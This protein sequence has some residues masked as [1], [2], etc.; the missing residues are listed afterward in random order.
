MVRLDAFVLILIKCGALFSP[1]WMMIPRAQNHL[2]LSLNSI[3]VEASNFS[4]FI[5]RDLQIIAAFP[6]NIVTKAFN[7]P[8]NSMLGYP[9]TNIISVQDR[10]RLYHAIETVKLRSSSFFVDFASL[11]NKPMHG[12]F[13]RSDPFHFFIANPLPIEFLPL[14]SMA[15]DCFDKV[16][17]MATDD[18]VKAGQVLQNLSNTSQGNRCSSCGT[19]ISG[20]TMYF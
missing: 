6:Q 8:L 14:L 20:K 11:Y 13:I 17:L 5:L 7:M 12:L 9:L 4:L 10:S 15:R 1:Q 19:R 2:Q 18:M 3:E 16:G